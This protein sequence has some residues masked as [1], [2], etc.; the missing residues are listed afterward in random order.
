MTIHQNLLYQN[1]E[2]S[3]A[4]SEQCQYVRLWVK[5]HGHR[6][7]WNITCW[8]YKVDIW[9]FVG[10]SVS[11]TVGTDASTT[12]FAGF[13][14]LQL[15]L[16]HSWNKKYACL[17]QWSFWDL[18]VSMNT[19]NCSLFFSEN[20]QLRWILNGASWRLHLFCVIL[21]DTFD[22]RNTE[23]TWGPW[24]STLKLHAT[25]WVRKVNLFYAEPLI[26]LQLNS[27]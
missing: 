14:Y 2:H 20:P 8:S 22:Q 23:L 21:T 24:M 7:S 4:L 6:S 27:K 15:A 10:G 19:T 3:H 25:M 17:W 26:A 16:I 12:V 1:G 18:P 11:F 13:E 9:F 5:H